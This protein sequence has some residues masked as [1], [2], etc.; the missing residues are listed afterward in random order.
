MY[1]I[2]LAVKLFNQF[3][4]ESN[5]DLIVKDNGGNPYKT[6]S[7]LEELVT[8]DGVIA[9]IGP[10]LSNNVNAIL[11]AANAFQVPVITPTASAPDVIGKSDFFL[12][13]SILLLSLLSPNYI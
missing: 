8:R 9:V 4:S 13:N 5:I 7:A 10:V 3:N 11:D 1:G 12:R 6:N 2:Q